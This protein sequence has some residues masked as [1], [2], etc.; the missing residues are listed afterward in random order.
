VVGV[1]AEEL[2]PAPTWTA[3]GAWSGIPLIC[4]APWA[5]VDVVA[6]GVGSGWRPRAAQP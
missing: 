1:R 6:L 3:L 4:F 2:L 5:V